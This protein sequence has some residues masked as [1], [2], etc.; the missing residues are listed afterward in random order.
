MSTGKVREA[1]DLMNAGIAMVKSL[2]AQ[3]IHPDDIVLQGDCFGAAIA[4]EV[5]EQLAKQANVDMRIVMN[6]S[7]KSFKAAVQD[8]ITSTTWL[9]ARLKDIVKALYNSIS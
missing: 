8:M 4:M 6:N 9:P 3:G 2:L 1:N 7:F 5:K